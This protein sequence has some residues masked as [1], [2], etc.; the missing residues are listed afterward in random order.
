MGGVL[1]SSQNRLDLMMAKAPAMTITSYE[2]LMGMHLVLARP[3][4]SVF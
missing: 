1:R 3:L 2:G 4:S